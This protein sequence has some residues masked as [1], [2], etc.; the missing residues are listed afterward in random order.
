MSP[1]ADLPLW[2]TV[3]AFILAAGAVWVAGTR[4]SRYADAIAREFGI[5]QA[6]LGVILLGGVTSLPE[7]AVTGTAALGGCRACL[8]SS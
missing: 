2:I 8:A 4:L 3:A 5:G 7:I 6:V 1:F